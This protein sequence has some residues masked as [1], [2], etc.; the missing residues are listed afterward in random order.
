VKE[1]LRK[2]GVFGANRLVVEVLA[3]HHYVAQSA[4]VLYTSSYGVF[5]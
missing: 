5:T 2:G 3:L 4:I 1:T